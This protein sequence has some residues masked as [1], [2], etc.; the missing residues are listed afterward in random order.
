MNSFLVVKKRKASPMLHSLALA[1]QKEPNS[2][3]SMTGLWGLVRVQYSVSQ[4]EWIARAGI[5]TDIRAS[6]K[7]IFWMKK[8]MPTSS[9]QE[10]KFSTLHLCFSPRRPN[11]NRLLSPPSMLPK[12]LSSP[13][14]RRKSLL[15]KEAHRGLRVNTESVAR[16]VNRVCKDS[17]ATKAIEAT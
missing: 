15:L 11:L 8:A 3:S 13:Q 7:P 10:P 6:E 12:S 4:P 14:G 16:E 9:K 1:P 5:Y 2:D 17:K